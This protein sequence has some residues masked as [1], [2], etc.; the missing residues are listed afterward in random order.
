MAA[1]HTVL[2]TGQRKIGKTS[3]LLNL[4]QQADLRRL[5]LAGVLSRGRFQSEVETGKFAVDLRTRESRLLASKLPGE[6]AGLQLGVW[7]FSED[8]LAWGNRCFQAVQ[9]C[10]IFIVDEIGPLELERGQGWV[11]AL[12]ALEQVTARLALVVVR[13]ECLPALQQRFP[14]ADR[15]ELAQD[16][17]RGQVA[18]QFLKGFGLEK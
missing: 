3:L 10:D 1:I 13:P 8:V 5:D 16:T 2:L 7:T 4:V 14:Q 18:A 17:N 12:S 11:A 9:T 15:V 6:L